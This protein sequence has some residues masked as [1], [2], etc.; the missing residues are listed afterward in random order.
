MSSI[1][2]LKQGKFTSINNSGEIR[3]GTNINP[4]TAGEA[5]VSNGPNQPVTWGTHTGT[6]NALT[7]GTNITY[8]SGN[9]TFDGSVADTINATDT[10]TTYTAGDGLDLTGTVFSTDLRA[11]SGLIITATELD[12]SA[13]PN[14]A[15]ANSS[16][17]LGSTSV[18]L[19]ATETTIE[20]LELDACQ[21]ITMD[22]ANIDMDCNDIEQV[23][24]ITYCS[25]GFATT[26]KGNDYPSSE[27]VCTYLDLTSATNLL[28]AAVAVSPFLATKIQETYLLKYV[29]TTY[30]E[31]STNFRTSF[32]AQSANVMVEFRAVIRCDN[33]VIYG[34]LYDYNAGAYW[35]T[36]QTQ[37][38]FNYNDETD[39][40]YSVFSWWI[41]GLTPGTTYYVSPYF[42][43]N[44][45][46]SYIYA[47]NGGVANSFAPGIFRIIDGGSNVSVY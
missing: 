40:D 23:E 44:T 4:G 34:A 12:L 28:P 41:D 21:G 30:Y 13:I 33:R 35:T 9:P 27:T 42:K 1:T 31:Y 32:V 16:I 6:I 17:T 37:N 14:S 24:D 19:G 5:I 39:Q 43:S 45:N 29:Y 3:L 46:T 22:G 7:A 20:D 47:G 26:L 11:G 36:P 25:G 8:T 2:G 18:S 15:L 38:R 10:D